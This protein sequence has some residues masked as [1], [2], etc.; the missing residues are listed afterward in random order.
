MRH[1]IKI[2]FN[3]ANG[4]SVLGKCFEGFWEGRIL[5]ILGRRILED[6]G[7]WPCLPYSESD[8][9]SITLRAPQPCH[10]FPWKSQ[11]SFAFLR[12]SGLCTVLL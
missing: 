3:P 6:G 9:L 12:G 1:E 8:V 5:G 4:S 2:Q 11:V 7:I 10:M